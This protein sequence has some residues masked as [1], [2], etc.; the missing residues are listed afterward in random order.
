[1]TFLKNISKDVNVI[2]DDLY[3]QQRTLTLKVIENAGKLSGKDSV[4]AWIAG[5]DGSV[6]RGSKMIAEFRSAGTVD[7]AQLALAN[8]QVR[9]M[10][11]G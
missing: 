8:R 10:I 9:A 2:I 5:D 3:G 1:M 11:V 7:M 4:K 6:E